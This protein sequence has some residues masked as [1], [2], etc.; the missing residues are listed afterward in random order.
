M[1][2]F[3][4]LCSGRPRVQGGPMVRRDHPTGQIWTSRHLRSH[5][6]RTYSHDGNLPQ[7]K[8][9][10]FVSLPIDR[11]SNCL[12]HYLNSTNRFTPLRI[13]EFVKSTWSCATGV[14]TIA[15][16]ASAI[17]TAAGIKSPTL[18]NPTPLGKLP[19]FLSFRITW[20]VMRD[21]L[22]FIFLLDVIVDSLLQDVSSSSP[23]I[24]D[25]CIAK[26]RL[27]VTWGQAVHL[28]CAIK[29]PEPM[30]SMPVT[31]YYYSREKGQYQLSF[32]YICSQT[33]N[34]A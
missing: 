19:V 11:F 16:V 30:S 26:K 18:V 5:I 4:F 23:G 22:L 34:F 12:L 28:S 32:R 27:L 31:W 24:C 20:W 10:H 13:I 2:F 17:L 3:F 15:C 33:S 14:T 21:G 9:A 7:S 6:S 8:L 29:L 25:A 1:F